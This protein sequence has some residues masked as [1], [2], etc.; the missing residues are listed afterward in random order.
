[1]IVKFQLLTPTAKAPLKM[2]PHSTGWDLSAD[3]SE[4]VILHPG[5]RISI[6]TGLAMEI[7]VGYEGQLRPRSGHALNLGL[8]ILNS[9][10]TIDPD[11]RGEI[12]VILCN[13]SQEDL[14]IKPGMRIVQVVISPVAEVDFAETD[15]LNPT[16]RD[17]GGFGH[18]GA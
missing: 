14:E 13:F 4:A 15:G 11:Y 2:T 3:L 16:L 10:G 18:T 9:P 1:M 5:E 17:L 8:G 6:P 7:P 12:K